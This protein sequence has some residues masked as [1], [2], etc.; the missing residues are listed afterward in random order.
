MKGCVSILVL[1]AASAFAAGERSIEQ[2]VERTRD[3]V[4]VVSQFGRDGKDEAVGA[5]FV[6]ASNLIGTAMHVIGESRQLSVRLASGKELEASEIHAWDR[7]MD[8][9]IIRVNATNLR[10]LSL[11]DSDDLHQGAGVIAIGNP[12]GLEHSVVQGLVS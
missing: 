10:P 11:G 1:G 6:I 3:S 9:A 12:L 5:G 7:K 4:V 8:L 2:L